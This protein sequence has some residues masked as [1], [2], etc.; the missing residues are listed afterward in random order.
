MSVW[1]LLVLLLLYR[2]TR[3]GWAIGAV[4]GHLI[5]LKID[6]SI[7]IGLSRTVLSGLIRFLLA[8][9]S[10]TS[11]V[12]LSCLSLFRRLSGLR[13]YISGD[14]EGFTIWETVTSADLTAA[15][16]WR[17]D[18]ACDLEHAAVRRLR[19]AMDLATWS[20]CLGR[21]LTKLL[22]RATLTDSVLR[23][24]VDGAGPME[25]VPVRIAG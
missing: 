22:Q 1:D 16:V 11:V 6:L 18:D 7:D 3:W 12:S 2:L 21:R 4:V 19:G 24:L 5:A 13:R 10:S 17:E 9:L 20:R 14:H 8:A 23:L 25:L 15:A